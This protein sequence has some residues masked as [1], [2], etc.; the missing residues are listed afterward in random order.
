MLDWKDAHDNKNQFQSGRYPATRVWLRGRES[1]Y[2]EFVKAG[3]EPRM[4]ATSLE[5][6]PAQIA[7]RCIFPSNP[8]TGGRCKTA[9]ESSRECYP[10]V[11]EGVRYA[12]GVYTSHI[13][14]YDKAAGHYA[15][16]QEP[17]KDGHWYAFYWETM[18]DPDRKGA[19]PS[20]P[21]PSQEIHHWD[22]VYPMALVV[23]KTLV[24]NLINGHQ[25]TSDKGRWH[26]DLELPIH[27]TMWYYGLNLDLVQ[28]RESKL[29]S[30]LLYTSPSP[31]D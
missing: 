3:F 10:N 24:Q 19:T 21:N 31:R 28:L 2:Y 14:D 1:L 27:G 6:L 26:P 8:H 12:T 17:F 4:H 13:A 20:S 29:R 5:C 16:F 7:C 9:N 22:G 23:V 15:R 30:C 25:T 11:Y 18:N